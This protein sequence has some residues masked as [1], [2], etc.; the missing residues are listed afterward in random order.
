M[1][2]FISFQASFF[3]DLIAAVWELHTNINSISQHPCETDFDVS[4]FTVQR[5]V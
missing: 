1:G 5:E 2:I 3:M 4:Y